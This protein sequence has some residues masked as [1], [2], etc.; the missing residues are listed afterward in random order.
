MCVFVFTC[1]CQTFSQNV[2]LFFFR[3]PASSLPWGIRMG[4]STSI[5]HGRNCSRTEL[6]TFQERATNKMPS[7]ALLCQSNHATLGDL[8]ATHSHAAS[9]TFV[10]ENHHVRRLLAGKLTSHPSFCTAPA[11]PKDLG[12]CRFVK[13]IQP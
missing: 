11:A 6:Q 5:F 13:E 10:E 7:C 8:G 1:M 4:R 12:S 2:F 3:L 9:S